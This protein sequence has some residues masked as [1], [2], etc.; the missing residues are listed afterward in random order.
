MRAFRHRLSLA[1]VLLLATLAVVTALLSAFTAL[2][3]RHEV[4]QQTQQLRQGLALSADQMAESLALP[5]WNIDD[6]GL[7]SLVAAGMSSPA[8]IAIEARTAEQH[9]ITQRHASGQLLQAQA[10]PSGAGLI[11]EERVVRRAGEE[12]G[13]V[14]LFATSAGLEAELAAWRRSAFQFILWLDLALLL[15]LGLLLWALLL[16]PVRALQRYAGAVQAGQRP[17]PPASAM[18]IGE[19]DKLRGSIDSMLAMLDS[20]YAELRDSQDRLQ[21]A[22]RAARLG[23]WDL[24]LVTDALRFDEAMYEIYGLGPESFDGTLSGW[25]RM[26]PS[27]QMDAAYAAIQAAVR[28]E[29]DYLFE[30]TLHQGRHIRSVATVVRDAQGRAV[31]MVGVNVD[32]TEQRR[33]EDEIRQLNAELEQR[34]EQRTAQLQVAVNELARARDEAQSATRAKSEFLANMSHEIRTPMNAVLGLTE[35]ALRGDLAP[36]QRDHIQ[37]AQGAA[38]ALLGVLNDILDV[39]KIEAG[40]LDLE[41]RAFALREVLDDALAVVQNA[42]Q[43]KGLALSL[44]LGPEVPAVLVGDGL[45]L[46]QVLVNLC[47]NALK[48]TERGEVAVQV[49]LASADPGACQLRFT[50]RDT[51]IGM[52]AAQAASVFEPFSQAD[53]STTRR[54]GGTGLGL[55]ICRKL[56]ALLGGEIGVRSAPGQ[57]SEFHF[58]A[59]F[60][61]PP[62]DADAEGAAAQPPSAATGGSS[63]ALTAK[64]HGRRVLLVEDNELNQIVAGELLREACGM[65]V[66]VAANGLQALAALGHDTPDLVLMD[67]QM[68]DMDGYE[69]TRR[70]RQNSAWARLPIIAMTAHAMA[71][72]RERCLAAGMDDYIAKPFDPE[73]LYLVL[74]RHL[75]PAASAPR[76]LAPTPPAHSGLSLEIGLRRCMGRTDLYRRIA[77]RFVETRG[78]LPQ[79][80]AA[81]LAAGQSAEAV[82]V[83]H[84]LI[85]SAGTLGAERLSALAR[86]LQNSLEA[87]DAAATHAGLADLATEHGRVLDALRAYLAQ[88]AGTAA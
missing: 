57:G 44:Q 70:I 37:K 74:A 32:I 67:V 18:F 19:L 28:G 26:R 75:A 73:E 42:A 69:V 30:F 6:T 40:R 25:R 77:Q 8:L 88:E 55:A 13:R 87:G 39:S 48:F 9:L 78:A 61:R 59:R 58:T 83:A 41:H 34:V 64:L 54:Y 66:T 29:K 12:I 36:R 82:R 33:S 45:R 11:V 60:G 63:P 50:V 68:P 2:V 46:E 1:A 27:A 31:R 86:T 4:T 49:A 62:A 56:V 23:V 20:R 72:D 24:D 10:P 43:D 80:L 38:Q 21:L 79:D 7:R 85:S 52:S 51:G 81:H 17:A 35:L 14:R 53:T 47:T 76:A 16:R 84:T 15:S 71:R 65:V 5:M 3:Y 22:A